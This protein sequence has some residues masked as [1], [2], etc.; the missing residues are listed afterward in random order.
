MG[1][2]GPF[3]C[4]NVDCVDPTQV[5]LGIRFGVLA[6]YYLPD[7]PAGFFPD[8]HTHVNTFRGYSA[9]TSARTCRPCPTGR[10]DWPD[11]DHIYDFIDVT[12]R[13][14]LPYGG[15]GP[16]GLDL[17]ALDS[18]GASSTPADDLSLI[19]DE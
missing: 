7:Q 17:P 6:A 1:D 5:R 19:G 11:N 16:E 9:P 12:D 3:L 4:R 13:L 2:E 10:I 8:D 18:P 14:P 15:N